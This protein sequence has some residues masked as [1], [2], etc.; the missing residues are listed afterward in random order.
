MFD[1]GIYENIKSKKNQLSEKYKELNT[2][3]QGIYEIKEDIRKTCKHDLLL[4]YNTVIDNTRGNQEYLIA[5]CLLCD[6]QYK[7]IHSEILGEQ[8]YFRYVSRERINSDRII[9]VLKFVPEE[10]RNYYSVGKNELVIEAQLALEELFSN[11]ESITKEEIEEEIKTR[12]INYCEG[13][14]NLFSENDNV[15]KKLKR[16]DRNE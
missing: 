3:Q 13:M 12:L 11:N 8:C 14:L 5:H 6:E 1:K 4:V 9:N 7:L 2:L 15:V 10:C 16:N